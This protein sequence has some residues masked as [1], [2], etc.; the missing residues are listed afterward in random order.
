MVGSTVDVNMSQK[1]LS[2]AEYLEYSGKPGVLYELYRGQ[3][4][5]MPTP[6]GLH[7]LI[8][9]YLTVEFLRYLVSENLNLV[10]IDLTGV[11]TEDKTS[12]I[13]DVVVYH[14]NF[15][16][17]VC[18]RSGAAVLDFKEKPLLVVEVTSQ[19]WRDDYGTKRD[20]Y[21]RL[22]IPEYWIVDPERSRVRLCSKISGE[23][24][25]AERDFLPGDEVKSAQ[26]PG[27]ILPVARILY[28]PDVDYLIR[29][30]L[31]LRQE[32]NAERQRAEAERQRAEAE[33]Q[34]AEAERQR[35]EAE[36]Q[37]AEAERQRAEQ[38]A[39]Y[40]QALGI[41]PDTIN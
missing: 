3:L 1:T 16:K 41:D 12:R 33:R 21:S 15:W 31:R 5:E 32:L 40:L 25:Y 4:I 17:N 18:A 7:N 27:F 8:C 39:Q 9:K 30:E 10:A 28:P 23:E 13:P 26:F 2:F 29:E 11:R 6:T 34:R 35:A 19:N 20:E 36:R 22:N 14:Q 38:L 24:S 37:R